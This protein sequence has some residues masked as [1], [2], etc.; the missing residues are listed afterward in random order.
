MLPLILLI[1]SPPAHAARPTTRVSVGS[2]NRQADGGSGGPE[3]EP[4]ISSD[5]RWVAFTSHANNLTPGQCGQALPRVGD[6]EGDPD[7]FV[8]DTLA[9]VTYPITSLY[10]C[11]ESANCNGRVAISADGRW[12][13]FESMLTAL[14]PMDANGKR[15]VYVFDAHT[16]AFARASVAS[17]G[18]ALGGHSSW[19]S[20][21]ADGRY[22][23]F[24]SGVTGT[25]CTAGEQIYRRDRDVDGDGIYDEPGA[26]STVLVSS[27]PDGTTGD[28]PSCRPS[29]SADGQRIAFDS[30]A[31]NLL[32]GRE[33]DR[34]HVFVRRFD[35]GGTALA[36]VSTAGIEGNAESDRPALSADGESVVFK[37]DASNLVPGD[38]NGK[39]DIFLYRDG[40][41]IRVSERPGGEQLED[42]SGTPSVSADGSVVSFS[43]AHKTSVDLD[44]HVFVRDL[45]KDLLLLATQSTAGAPAD[46]KSY[47]S[48]VS[49]DGHTIAYSSDATNLVPDDTNEATDVFAHVLEALC[50][51]GTEKDGP[52]SRPWRDEVESRAG[53]AWPAAGA[54]G[55]EM[56]RRGL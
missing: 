42:E 50:A 46:K 22:V 29:I 43:L 21:S 7:I 12:V 6:C 2:D 23:A 3:L 26:T 33:T 51:D 28:G 44:T 4:A 56:A 9:G 49:A 10:A 53:P 48:V 35:L 39:S 18:S 45:V 15:D 19:P 41:T 14:D 25:P 38:T 11:D 24:Q 5:G 47:G 34:R 31:A 8:R 13:A 27:A 52:V 16:G 55:C 30:S 1:A 32:A 37:S 40:E 17:D 20:L 36:S 54:A